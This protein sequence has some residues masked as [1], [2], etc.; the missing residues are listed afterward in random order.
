VILEEAAATVKSPK[1]TEKS[2]ALAHDATLLEQKHNEYVPAEG[3][4]LARSDITVPLDNALIK[5]RFAAPQTLA[6]TKT[7][8][9]SELVKPSPM[10]ASNVHAK[11]A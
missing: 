4:S 7:P 5:W 3:T 10:I 1:S 8:T 2:P 11:D 9:E 6:L